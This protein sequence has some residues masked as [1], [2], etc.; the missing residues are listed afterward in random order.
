[1]TAI[2]INIA[3]DLKRAF[4]KAYPDETIEAGVERVLR[5]EIDRR[6]TLRAPHEVDAI[7]EAFARV[8][9]LTKPLSDDEIRELR[10]EGRK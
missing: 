1:M 4:E 2:T 10:H 8:Q 6:R 5:A 9:K 3:D 7:L